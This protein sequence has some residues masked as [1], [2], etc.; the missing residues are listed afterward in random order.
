[1][2]IDHFIYVDKKKIYHRM[3]YTEIIEQLRRKGTAKWSGHS[4]YV[5]QG[6]IEY[7][8]S[9]QDPAHAA[10]DFEEWRRQPLENIR[11]T[12]DGV[13][14]PGGRLP[15]TEEEIRKYMEEHKDD[16]F[17]FGCDEAEEDEDEL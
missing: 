13:E 3:I 4:V 17:D 8:Y 9:Y 5:M 14:Q 12:L 15:L 10:A 2:S 16:D 1:M 7:L 6:G 11:L